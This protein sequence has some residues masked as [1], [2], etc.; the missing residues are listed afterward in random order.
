[1]LISLVVILFMLSFSVFFF[2]MI[3]RP[4]RS[5]RTDTLFPYPTL[6]RSVRQPEPLG[7]SRAQH[8]HAGADRHERRGAQSSEL[9]PLS[10][11]SAD[12]R[13][14]PSPHPVRPVTSALL[15]W[16]RP[17]PHLSCQVGGRFSRKASMPSVASGPIMLLTMTALAWA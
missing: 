15:P 12:R 9:H 14:L 13:Q 10:S 4:P 1:M 3:R 11:L 7:R 8:R 17:E 5:T 2:L 6:F 16:R